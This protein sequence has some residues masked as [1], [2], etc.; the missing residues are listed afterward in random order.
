[1]LELKGLDLET[2]TDKRVSLTAAMVSLIKAMGKP[3]NSFATLVLGLSLLAN[4]TGIFTAGFFADDFTNLVRFNRSWGDLSPMV[5]DGK[6]TMNLMWALGTLAFGASTPIPYLIAV[7]LLYW[8]GMVI[9]ALS[10]QVLGWYSATGSLWILSFQSATSFYLGITLWSSNVVHAASVFFIGL[11]FLSFVQG[12]VATDWKFSGRNS[13]FVSLFIGL[14]IVSNPLYLGFALLSVK[15]AMASRSLLIQ[16]KIPER[17]LGFREKLFVY[18]QF[19]AAISPIVYS[20]FIAIP[21]VTSKAIYSLASQSD[22]LSNLEFY[23]EQSS[24]LAPVR[25]VLAFVLITPLYSVVAEIARRRF[26]PLIL[27]AA[28]LS[29]FAILLLQSSQRSIH[30]LTMPMAVLVVLAVKAIME[31]RE[32]HNAFLRAMAVLTGSL[33]LLSVFVGSTW[34]RSWFT[35]Q[36]HTKSVNELRTNVFD[37][38]RGEDKIC[39]ELAMDDSQSNRLVASI[40]GDNGF[41]VYPFSFSSVEFRAEGKCD[42][43]PGILNVVVHEKGPWRFEVNR[44]P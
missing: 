9:F 37:L 21:S 17:G 28:A 7:T 42:N 35:E 44:K 40:G 14:A 11:A 25:V 1:M 29:V 19:I 41:R 12:S 38:A 8:L 36:T 30:Y 16:S 4:L 32:S 20:F 31:V 10:G 24:A 18:I 43:R 27:L 33:V 2:G 26:V 6:F 13:L 22:A 23:W 3:T 34:Q 39:L 15:S 5:N